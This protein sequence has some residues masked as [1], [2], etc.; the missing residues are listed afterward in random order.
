MDA[1]GI[2]G[3][4]RF[5]C[6]AIKWREGEEVVWEDRHIQNHLQVFEIHF[7][8]PS[9]IYLQA[10]NELCRDEVL[11][12]FFVMSALT[13]FV[14]PSGILLVPRPLCSSTF[15]HFP[16]L[17]ERDTP[18]WAAKAEAE[19]CIL[20]YFDHKLGFHF[21]PKMVLRDSVLIQRV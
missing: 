21:T 2:C 19:R 4:L 12:A 3:Q 20:D 11:Q 10:F 14:L 17:L 9:L 5:E 15:V 7:F 1:M 16:S 6:L 13:P 8:S 18:T